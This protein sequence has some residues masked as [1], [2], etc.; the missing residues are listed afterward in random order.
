M[1]GLRL[2]DEAN[3]DR[4]E[5]YRP[6]L[7]NVHLPTLQKGSAA[8]HR[9]HRN[10]GLA[11][12]EVNVMYQREDCLIR[13]SL[14]REKAQAHP[15]RSDYWTER[16]VVWHQ[17]AVHANDGKAITYQIHNGRMIAKSTQ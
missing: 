2:T 11:R 3:G 9:K 12:A 17:R 13:A 15:E 4:A 5:R 14:C 6:R 7:T 10:C 1:Y 8:Y 16:A